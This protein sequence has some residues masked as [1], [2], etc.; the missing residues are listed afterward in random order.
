MPNVSPLIETRSDRVE[1]TESV[2]SYLIVGIVCIMWWYYHA[3]T[4]LSN[5]FK[6]FQQRWAKCPLWFMSYLL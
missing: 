2:V 6:L 5:V 3:T 1:A 4:L